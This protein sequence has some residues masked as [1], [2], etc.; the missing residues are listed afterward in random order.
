MLVFLCVFCQLE[1]ESTDYMFV[2][3]SHI[4]PI[5]YS[6]FRWLDYECVSHRSILGFYESFLGMSV[7]RKDT[8]NLTCYC[9]V[10][11]KLLK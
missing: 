9:A 8:V 3:C 5:W 10:G 1:S 4:L 7:G 2:S 11:L 6:I